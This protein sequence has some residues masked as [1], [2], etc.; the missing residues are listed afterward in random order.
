MM[1]AMDVAGRR[2]GMAL[3][4]LVVVAGLATA[5]ASNASDRPVLEAPELPQRRAAPSG[6]P[7]PVTP[8]R[9][10]G[11]AIGGTVGTAP[12]APAAPDD[13]TLREWRERGEREAAARR[14]RGGLTPPPPATPRIGADP[15]PQP[16]PV[17]VPRITV[18][19]AGEPGGPPIGLP[20]CGPAG[21]FDANGR[22]LPGSGGVLTG[23][24]G[25]P[26]VRNGATATCL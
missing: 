2:V 5:S 13:A 18:P 17:A 26:C 23:P 11:D 9:R 3:R 14:D 24:G 21:C 12:A 6:V 10:A 7:H 1:R 20:T 25:R 16:P 22:V 19:G 15:P 8:A 4:A